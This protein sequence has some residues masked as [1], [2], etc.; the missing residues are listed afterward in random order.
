MNAM[1]GA[2]SEHV[3]IVHIVGVP[4]TIAQKDGQLLHHTLGNGNFN[5]SEAPT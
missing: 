3:P 1:A 2:Y 5:V 4:S